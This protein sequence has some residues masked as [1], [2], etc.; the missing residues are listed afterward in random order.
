[1]QTL[2]G[3]NGEAVLSSNNNNNGRTSST[4]STGFPSDEDYH[5]LET[6]QSNG[7]YDHNQTEFYSSVPE[8]KYRP[9]ML[10]MNSGETI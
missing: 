2:N 4:G 9:P 8:Q 7:F 10:R 3:I 1:M 6:N 5:R